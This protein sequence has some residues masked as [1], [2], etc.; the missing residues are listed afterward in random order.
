MQVKLRIFAGTASF[1]SYENLGGST[2]MP[3]PGTN[4]QLYD[5]SVYWHVALLD[6]TPSNPNIC[7][8]NVWG[9][10]TTANCLLRP[11]INNVF[12][13]TYPL[14]FI[15]VHSVCHFFS[16]RLFSTSS[17]AFL[18]VLTFLSPC[19]KYLLF[20]FCLVMLHC[21]F[22]KCIAQI[23]SSPRGTIFFKTNY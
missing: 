15:R 10:Y 16:P 19:S 1:A 14:V 23:F 4:M 9:P 13:C 18:I 6:P 17:Q 2:R 12:F 21:T 11:Q 8:L 20:S 22:S 7:H 3:F 5:E